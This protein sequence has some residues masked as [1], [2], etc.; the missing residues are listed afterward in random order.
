MSGRIRLD[1]M[2]TGTL[3]L[4]D[5]NLAFDRMHRGEAIRTVIRF[6]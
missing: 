3:P 4:A 5:I 6:G 1:E 2:I